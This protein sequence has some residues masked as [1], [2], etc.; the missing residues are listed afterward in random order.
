M[1]SEIMDPIRPQA[2]Y[3]GDFGENMVTSLPLNKPFFRRFQRK[4]GKESSIFQAIFLGDFGEKMVMNLP[5]F[6]PFF[7]RFR[8]KNGHEPSIEQTIF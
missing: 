8:R 3:L 2:I 4:N 5:F 6:K 7:R 1:F